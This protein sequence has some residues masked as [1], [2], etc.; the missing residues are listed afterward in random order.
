MLRWGTARYGERLEGEGGED[1]RGDEWV[2]GEDGD[3]KWEDTDVHDE[4]I[5]GVAE[6]T[7]KQEGSGE[8]GDDVEGVEDTEEIEDERERLEEEGE[9][10][11]D[12]EEQQE[13]E[14]VGQ[15]EESAVNED[16]SVTVCCGWSITKDGDL[17]SAWDES[18]ISYSGR[19]QDESG[20]WCDMF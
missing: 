7:R 17:S 10:E 5:G 8:G 3:E 20:L 16:D 1:G 18:C 12:A 13:G 11:E 19:S 2:G 14:D 4:L 6:N 9:D 15:E